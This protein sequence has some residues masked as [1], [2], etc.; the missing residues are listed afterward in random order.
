MEFILHIDKIQNLN[1]PIA[2]FL[3]EL[4]RLNLERK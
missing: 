3:P 4:S 2:D 1:K